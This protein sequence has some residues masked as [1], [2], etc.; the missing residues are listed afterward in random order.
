[1][2][3]AACDKTHKHLAR[4]RLREFYL[5]DD[6]RF[7]ELL[8]HRSANPHAKTLPFRVVRIPRL[9]PVLERPMEY[10]VP[11]SRSR[12]RTALAGF[13]AL[14]LVVPAAASAKP[15]SKAR[16]LDRVQVTEY[17]PVPEAWFVG[18]KV[19]AP[20]LA[21]KH[22]IDWLYSARGVS[23][24]GTGIGLDGTFFHIDALGSGGWV[25]DQARPSVPGR[26]AWAG[27]PPYWR[28]GGY[29]LAKNHRVTFPLEA[30]GWSNGRGK[31]YVDLPGVTFAPGESKPLR[32][33]RS[34]A[35][36]PNLIPLGSRVYVA[37]YR[38]TA[39]HG[40]F[41]AEDVGGAIDGRHID[42]YRSPPE[43]PEAGASSIPSARIYVIPPG[44]KRGKDGPTGSPQVPPATPAPG[45]AP[46]VPS[47]S[48]GGGAGAP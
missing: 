7:A 26:G 44:Q 34:I 29:W 4:S 33:Y 27:G 39:G 20:G 25:T 12:I 14:A 16:W 3:D 42:V 2:T 1:M 46:A 35:V 24:Q 6:Q 41:V 5:L 13:A 28:A 15:I 11:R 19:A 8:E 43:S 45:E 38:D 17:Y 10:S 48:T 18:K 32:Y 22:R 23:M 21:D 47:P 9:K 40:W 37:D 36:D 30:G 31:R